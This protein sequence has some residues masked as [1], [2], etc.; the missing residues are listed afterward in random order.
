M[1]ELKLETVTLFEDPSFLFRTIKN[2]LS[3]EKIP[4][5]YSDEEFDIK[6]FYKHFNPF[7]R[8]YIRNMLNE[9]KKYLK[10]SYLIIIIIKYI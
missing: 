8:M 1:E 7:E 9:K 3:M 5:V 4:T 10:K 2:Y 6:E